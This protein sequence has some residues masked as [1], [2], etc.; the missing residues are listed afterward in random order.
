M[1]KNILIIFIL[2]IVAGKANS[3]QCLNSI[4]CSNFEK[5]FPAEII[6]TES[7]TWQVVSTDMNAGNYTLFS[8]TEG[9]TYEG[10]RRVNYPILTQGG[11]DNK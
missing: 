5:Q 7:S 1:K 6:T 11:S 2:L 10:S 8:V 3:Q 9:N 4:G